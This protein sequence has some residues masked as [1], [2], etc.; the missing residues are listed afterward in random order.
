M[1]DLHGIPALGERL[2]DSILSY[3]KRYLSAALLLVCILLPGMQYLTADFTHTG[4]FYPDDPKLLAFEKFERQFGNDDSLVMVVHSPSG[5]FDEDS[6]KLIGELTEAMW[7]LPDIIR[8]TSLANYSWVHAEGDDI[9]VEPFIPEDEPLT[10]ALL[11][12][13]KKIALEHEN[14][15]N[16]LISPDAKTALIY[17]ALRPSLDS[18]IPLLPIVRAARALKE[19]SLRTDHV[20]YVY[21]GPAVTGGF[22][23]ATQNDLERLI[24]IVIGLIVLWLG[25]CLRSIRGIFLAFSVVICSLLGA[26]SVLGWFNFSMTSMTGILPQ[27]II[28][29]GVADAVHILVVFRQGRGEGLEP[30]EATRYTLL[31]NFQPTLLTSISTSIGFFSFASSNLKSLATLGIVAGFSVLFAWLFTYFVLGPLLVLAPL[32]ASRKEGRDSNREERIAKSF[33][34][35]LNRFKRPIL[36]FFT[37][38]AVLSCFA[39]TQNSVNAD[40]FKYF[41]PGYPVR[42][43]NDFLTEVMGGAG[44]F[45]VVIRTGQ[46]EGIKDPALL[47]K[48]DAYQAW[49]ESLPYVTQAVSIVDVLKATNRS[50]HGDKEEFYKVPDTREAVSQELFLYT[51]SLPQGMDINHQV[52]VRNDA[53]RMTVLWTIFDSESY[54]RERDVI[55]AKGREM[56]LDV[57]A[58]GKGE[59]YQ[60]MNSYVVDSFI[61]SISIAMVLVT[62]LLMFVFKSVRIGLIALIPNCLPLIFGGAFFYLFDKPLDIG[63]VLVMSV[64]L[65]I[66]VDDT[67]HML[68]NYN[69]LVGEG[70]SHVEALTELFSHTSP[71]LIVT[72]LILASGFGT[73]AFADFIPNMY[74]GIMTA[75]ILSSALITDLLFLPLLLEKMNF[76]RKPSP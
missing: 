44:G 9:L 38:I 43:A 12:Q 58:V 57:V 18:Q 25:V 49:V 76:G 39:S 42:D 56:G 37:L 10:Q 70:L 51:M 61:R 23:E 30:L 67:I 63:T 73:L 66:A 8:V 13:R 19:K 60:S 6:V 41:A 11:E 2:V 64:C 50:L 31:K 14:I 24:P 15:P 7:L 46:E 72:T 4:F 62:F 21:G 35:L 52:T 33:V 32:P 71:A 3:P 68:A 54:L 65:G 20:L 26:F 48:V 16:Y 29:I 47:L 45:N 17:A 59:I 34:R 5:I 55:L 75:L 40:P 27:I 36:I 53:L 22:E 69:R 1:R 74:F 28:A